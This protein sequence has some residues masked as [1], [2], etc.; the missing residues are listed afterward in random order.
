MLYRLCLDK[1]LVKEYFLRFHPHA[2]TNPTPR[3]FHRLINDI[4]LYFS[5][6]IFGGDADW[7]GD[8]VGSCFDVLDFLTRL[9]SEQ[10]LPSDDMNHFLHSS[11]G[12]KDTIF[13]RYT[14]PIK[15]DDMKKLLIERKEGVLRR[16]NKRGKKE[17]R[18]I[19]VYVND[20]GGGMTLYR[21]GK[22]DAKPCVI[23]TKKSLPR[24]DVNMDW[25]IEFCNAELGMKI[26]K[27]Y[28]VHAGQ[29]ASELISSA[30]YLKQTDLKRIK[31]TY[32]CYEAPLIAWRV[33]TA[34]VAMFIGLPECSEGWPGKMWQKWYSV[35]MSDFMELLGD[36]PA[37]WVRRAQWQF[38]LLAQDLDKCDEVP[39]LKGELKENTNG[40]VVV[41]L[42]GDDKEK[43]H[44]VDF[45]KMREFTEWK[46]NVQEA[47]GAKKE[48]E[49]EEEEDDVPL[50]KLKESV[51][52]TSK[53]M[54]QEASDA[55]GAKKPED[56]L[57]KGA[58]D[59]MELELEQEQETSDAGATK[60]P[61]DVVD[62]TINAQVAEAA[63]ASS[64]L[65]KGASDADVVDG[66]INAQ[67]AA[68]A[69]ATKQPEDELEKGA[70][71]AD[72]V[73]GTINAQVAAAAAATKQ[74]E[75]VVDGTI[76]AQVAAAATKQPDGNGGV[77]D[78]TKMQMVLLMKSK[79]NYAPLPPRPPPLP[80]LEPSQQVVVVPQQQRAS[81][82]EG[83]ASQTASQLTHN[84]QLHQQSV[85]S[86][87]AQEGQQQVQQQVRRAQIYPY[88]IG[89]H[90]VRN[91]P[92]L[93]ELRAAT[94]LFS[95]VN[96]GHLWFGCYTAN[97]QSVCTAF[98]ELFYPPTS[99]GRKCTLCKRTVYSSS[100]QLYHT[101]QLCYLDELRG[102]NVDSVPHHLRGS[103]AGDLYPF[104]APRDVAVLRRTINVNTCSWPIDALNPFCRLVSYHT[105]HPDI[106]KSNELINNCAKMKDS[107]LKAI[108]ESRLSQ[109]GRNFDEPWAQMHL[110][111]YTELSPYPALS[112]LKP[113]HRL[114]LN[115]V[116]LPQV[117]TNT[118]RLIRRIGEI[119]T[120]EAT[121][122]KRICTLLS[123]EEQNDDSNE[124]AVIPTVG[125][126]AVELQALSNAV[127]A[128]PELSN[129]GLAPAPAESTTNS[130]AC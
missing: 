18:Q 41:I 36:T 96:Y 61:E 11:L 54:E 76:N 68:A 118:R 23:S 16:H 37:S 2:K 46:W 20:E 39:L 24:K 31:E 93:K 105:V 72:V 88:V 122:R 104:I 108:L 110:T 49:E 14:G 52:T 103:Y 124:T 8:V 13:L 3:G 43:L 128:P 115:L 75:D 40:E 114:P 100:D 48:E 69:A 7:D 102:T 25:L 87:A 60:Q 44:R 97:A 84:S 95:L 127:P 80:A 65:E 81:D 1:W 47:K 9:P 92:N 119:E 94:P 59:A 99:N 57:E 29:F 111:T 125:A 78:Q 50:R 17:I 112:M 63:A 120:A 6:R 126:R 90:E 26:G 42:G 82:D 45:E 109:L 35:N 71:D 33:Y 98:Q 67:V 83:T 4:K 66:T 27:T 73:D 51:E 106:K 62:G 19:N 10:S 53:Q 86:D 130:T 70:S 64:E 38:L 5:Y 28:K 58:S 101:E 32:Y 116:P 77:G 107:E 117:A 21:V 85:D 55:Q 30:I 12:K 129:A 123:G 79:A 121:N 56:V 15:F 22:G 89:F 91:Q 113:M 34:A 74:P